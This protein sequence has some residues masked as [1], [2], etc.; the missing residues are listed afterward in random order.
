MPRAVLPYLSTLDLDAS[1]SSSA[2]CCAAPLHFTIRSSSSSRDSGSLLFLGPPSRNRA[3]SL[4]SAAFFSSDS[5][6]LEDHTN[7]GSSLFDEVFDGGLRPGAFRVVVCL[8]RDGVLTEAAFGSPLVSGVPRAGA[9]TTGDRKGLR[10][11]AFAAS[12]RR[13]FAAGK[14]DMSEKAMGKLSLSRIQACGATSLLLPIQKEWS[15]GH[16]SVLVITFHLS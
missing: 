8:S 1:K 4:S 11:V 7:V 14:F 15:D 2:A 6:R 9:F 16:A 3:I 13:L 10:R 12:T 5:S